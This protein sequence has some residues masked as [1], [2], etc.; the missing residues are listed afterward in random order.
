MVLPLHNRAGALPG[1]VSLTR[2]GSSECPEQVPRGSFSEGVTDSHISFASTQ[3]GLQNRKKRVILE[4]SA[5]PMETGEVQLDKLARTSDKL[6]EI[7][8]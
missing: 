6:N 8:T 3:I 1:S 4:Q 2:A 7:R 5:L